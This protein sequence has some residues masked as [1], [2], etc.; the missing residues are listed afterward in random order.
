MVNCKGTDITDR[1]L[2]KTAAPFGITLQKNVKECVFFDF[3]D[4]FLKN[5]YLEYLI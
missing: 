1:D 4:V 2:I 5:N 3:F